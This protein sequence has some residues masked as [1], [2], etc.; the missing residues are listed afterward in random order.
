MVQVNLIQVWEQSTNI[1]LKHLDKLA[2]AVSSPLQGFHLEIFLVGWKETFIAIPMILIMMLY[3]M[4]SYIS[5]KPEFF[6]I[7]RSVSL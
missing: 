3:N 6:Q 7:L 4:N 2:A 1:V 5:I